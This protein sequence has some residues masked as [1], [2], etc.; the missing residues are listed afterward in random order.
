MNVSVA[1]S[2]GRRSMKD[3]KADVHLVGQRC[4]VG[5]GDSESP[6]K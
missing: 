1:T 3:S 6:F 2:G 5:Q 4:P